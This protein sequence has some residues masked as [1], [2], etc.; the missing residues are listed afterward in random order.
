MPAKAR[1][2]SAAAKP[3]APRRTRAAATAPPPDAVRSSGKRCPRCD[4][5]ALDVVDG[6]AGAAY[7]CPGAGCGFALPV[8]ARRRAIPC[9]QCGGTVLE[10]RGT[11]ASAWACARAGCDYRVPLVAA[12]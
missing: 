9:P 10:R 5:A 1:K 4:R 8:G 6:P 2:R 12:G 7:R 3:A 11:A